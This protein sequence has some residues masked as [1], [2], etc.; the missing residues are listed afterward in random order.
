MCLKGMTTEEDRIITASSLSAAV[1][2]A[3]TEPK[4]K[5]GPTLPV[6]KVVGHGLPTFSFA[7]YILH[8]LLHLILHPLR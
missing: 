4:P 1:V 3:G 7:V 2:R 5:L 6:W 8:Q